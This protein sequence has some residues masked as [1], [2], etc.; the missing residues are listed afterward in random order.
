[1][2]TVSLFDNLIS[3]DTQGLWH[4]AAKGLSGLLVNDELTRCESLARADTP[5]DLKGFPGAAL[6][7]QLSISRH[8]IR[9]FSGCWRALHARAP[10]IQ[11][12]RTEMC[13]SACNFDPLSRGIGVQ[14]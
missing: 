5:C 12:S 4:S 14:N 11:R 10:T 8:W 13:Y 7:E 1:M 9:G 3:S 2:D 6:P